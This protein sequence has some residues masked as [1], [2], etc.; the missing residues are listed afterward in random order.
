VTSVHLVPGNSGVI[1]GRT[2]VVKVGEGGAYRVLAPDAGLKVSLVE[3]AYPEGRAPTSVIGAMSILK[4]PG[5]DCA[6]ALEPLRK[7]AT[8]VFVSV[9]TSRETLL[10]AGLRRDLGFRT[11]VLSDLRCARF[12]ADLKDGVAGVV[13][14]AVSNA[15]QPYEW[16]QMA[17]LFASGVPV[18]FA[19]WSPLRSPT[20]LRLSAVIA[21]RR[22][23]DPDRALRAIT[24]DAAKILG[25]DAS[26]GSLKA[27]KDAD[28]VVMSGPVTDARSR[29]LM[30]VQDGKVVYRAKEG[31][32]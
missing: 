16:R 24:L 10:A 23:I 2:S 11:V 17:D 22:G 5:E 1:G 3:E 12:A 8:N 14:D 19:T 6:K 20:A 15:R 29:V 26:I 4:D 21:A 7:G 25:V 27:G 18:A 30:C 31:S 9:A 28:L 13:L 32:P